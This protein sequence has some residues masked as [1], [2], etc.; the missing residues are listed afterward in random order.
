MVGGREII[1]QCHQVHVLVIVGDRDV[2]EHA[3]CENFILRLAFTAFRLSN[4]VVGGRMEV[5][6]K[7]KYSPF[8]LINY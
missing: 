4:L 5:V 7:T 3:T 1:F 8:R 6:Y 2:R